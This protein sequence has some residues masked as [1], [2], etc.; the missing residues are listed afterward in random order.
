MLPIAANFNRKGKAA[1]NAPPNKP[2]KKDLINPPS[3][4]PPLP[5][6]PLRLLVISTITAFKC[7]AI[8]KVLTNE[9]LTNFKFFLKIFSVF[10]DPKKFV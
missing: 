4:P 7:L 5:S 1:I 3:N 10:F 9:S 6:L 8:S 2:P